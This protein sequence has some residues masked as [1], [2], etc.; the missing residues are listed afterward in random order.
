MSNG[1]S[2]VHYCN[3]LSLTSV[4]LPSSHEGLAGYRRT[5]LLIGDRA[6]ELEYAL[7]T[8]L[9]TSFFADALFEGSDWAPGGSEFE[10]CRVAWFCWAR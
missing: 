9:M 3:S 5:E 2:S 7:P 10:E 8:R 1:T 4:H 6:G